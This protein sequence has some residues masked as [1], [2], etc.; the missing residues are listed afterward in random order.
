MLILERCNT[1]FICRV[2]YDFGI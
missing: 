1:Y 2:K